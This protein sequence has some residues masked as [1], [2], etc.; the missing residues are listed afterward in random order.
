MRRILFAL[1]L[2]LLSAVSL[3]ASPAESE[4]PATG[5]VASL[6]TCTPGT[7]A[8]EVYGHTALRLR[9]LSNPAE[10]LV[11]NYGVFDFNTDYFLWRWVLG[12]TDY[13]AMAD[14]YAHFVNQYEA[15]GRRVIEQP[16]NLT[17]AEV[18]RLYQQVMGD[19]SAA[20]YEHW[21]YR[22]NFFFDN[23]T[24]RIIDAIEGCLSE[25]SK[26]V[27]PEAQKQSLRDMLHQFA[28]PRSPW[29]SEGQ[30]WLIGISV[31][32][33]A[34]M[35][36]QLFSPIWASHYAAKAQIVRPDGTKQALVSGEAAS[37]EPVAEEG[38][39]VKPWMVVCVPFVIFM[40]LTF[41]LLRVK[42][43][44]YWG[45]IAAIH[46]LQGLIGIIITFLFFFSTHPGVDSNWLIVMC[47]PLWFVATAYAWRC[48]Y[49]KPQ[50]WAETVYIVVLIAT[51]IAFLVSSSCGQKYPILAQ[52]FYLVLLLN[53]ILSSKITYAKK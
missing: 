14:T 5:K 33:P 53:P 51:L 11:V 24:T 1:S 38:F 47:N 31:D 28:E 16:L 30:D 3:I 23:C 42:A 52:I 40:A 44:I 20:Y 25:G 46:A 27:W 13:T 22:Y 19:A 35:R 8:Y 29:L 36:H 2:A 37:V 48:R 49:K 7:E 6:L 43:Q 4:A 41:G 17:P 10:D 50:G 45:C 34:P 15:Q 18:E 9:S 21:T 12:K 39:M 26:V 32:S